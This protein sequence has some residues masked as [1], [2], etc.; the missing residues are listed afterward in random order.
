MPWQQP[1]SACVRA[2]NVCSATSV[3]R[4]RVPAPGNLLGCKRNGPGCIL[5]L[6]RQVARQGNLKDRKTSFGKLVSAANCGPGRRELSSDTVSQRFP[7]RFLVLGCMHGGCPM[8]TGTP[9]RP[10]GPRLVK[11]TPLGRPARGSERHA[12][13][14]A[15][16][17]RCEQCWIR[18]GCD[19]EEGEGRL[20]GPM[21][22]GAR[23]WK[24][25]MVNSQ[26]R[27]WASTSRCRRL[28]PRE[29]LLWSPECSLETSA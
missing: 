6:Q 25:C 19:D 15:C 4:V 10:C 5:Q 28:W 23:T 22:S 1:H 12:E 27:T 24:A 17:G 20:S 26:R 13:I 7:P 14:A 29:P 3:P 21:P 9:T 11:H 18:F 16:D 8:L 2:I